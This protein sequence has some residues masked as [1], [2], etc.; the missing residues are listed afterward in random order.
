MA[1]ERLEPGDRELFSLVTRA[2]YVNPFSP[3]RDALDARIAEA[4]GADPDLLPRLLERLESRLAAIEAAGELAPELFAPED[5]PVLEHAVLFETFHRY[6]DEL[7][8]LIEAQLAAGDASVEVPFADALLRRVIGRGV[9]E[10]KAVRMLS[11]FW[12]M[13]RA[14]YFIAGSLI[15]VSPSVRRLRQALWDDVFTHDIARYEQLLWDRLEDFSLILRGE[16]GSGK[17]Q[18]AAAIGRSGFVPFDPHRRAFTVSFT[19]L[20]VPINLS[21]F[22]ESLIESELFGHKKGAF[23]GAV[24]SH[25]GVFSRCSPNG[26]IFLDEI[27]EVSIPVQIKLLRV[28]QDRVFTPVGSHEE[29]RFEG[30]VI[31]AT[32][33]DLAT[34]RAEKRFRDDFYYRLCS[35][36]IEVPPLRQRLA[37]EPKELE[38]L[39]EHLVTR[40]VG[41]A[42]EEIVARCKAAIETNMPRGYAWPG[43]VRELEQCVRRVLLTG[44]CAPDGTP[45]L[46]DPTDR[47]L[48]EARDGTMEARELTARY[49][50]LLHER[51][52]TYEEVARI[53]GLDRRTVRKY[54]QQVR[55]D[56]DSG[57]TDS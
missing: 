24:D 46:G 28:L 43:N 4:D 52:G 11:L 51:C 23:T 55:G 25:A 54:V 50:A 42:D 40:I 16:T 41:A 34:L 53:T 48:A 3:E 36:V 27:G 20:F 31:A 8:A 2:A 44:R 5:W 18:A 49:C 30:R 7:D 47:F 13:R 57:A 19:E 32:H 33:R 12:Q 39:L 29:R 35:D 22:P 38:V 1:L 10:D 17:G 56:A 6:V 9:S 14:Y 15:G 37:E 45:A 26:A 21:Q